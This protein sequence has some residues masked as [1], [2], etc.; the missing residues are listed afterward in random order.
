M[1]FLRGTLRDR[2]CILNAHTPAKKTKK[3]GKTMNA[4]FSSSHRAT[5]TFA[6]ISSAVLLLSY[7]FAA[8]LYSSTS[9]QAADVTS[10]S[11]A[12]A[13]SVEDVETNYTIGFTVPANSN[14]GAVI[15][16]FCDNDPIPNTTCTFTA[17][18][19]D[20][21][22]VDTNAGSIA[23]ES[24]GDAFAFTGA[25]VSECDNP[26][27]TAPAVGSQF[28][29]ITCTAVDDF[30]NAAST[31]SGTID[32]IDNPS[33]AT[34]SPANPNNTFYARIYVYNVTNPTNPTVGSGNTASS[35]NLEHT[36]GIA[37]S[38]AEQL[39]ITA[40]VQEILEFCVGTNATAPADC[41]AMTGNSVD[42]GVLDFASINRST[43]QSSP[44]QG[45]VM[46]RTNA[47][48]GINIDYFA[49][50]ATTGTNH[51][52][53]MRV[54]GAN[55]N[56][57]DVETD[58]CLLSAGTTQNT[59]T[60][61]TEEFGMCIFGI[62][63]SSGTTTNFA[64]GVAGDYDD[65]A[66][67]CDN[68]AGFAFDETGTADDLIDTSTVVNDEMAEIEFAATSAITTP[69]GIYE[70]TITFIGTSTF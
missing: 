25:T 6:W 7:V 43:Q 40:R 65:I 42:L 64:G 66:N 10:R 68:T 11:I 54:D 53:A 51:L 50:Q 70:T 52:G 38:T 37:M 41:S 20:I 35:T 36:G 31:F 23:T 69:T 63:T 3:K 58:Q 22:Q 13:S 45:S 59:I 4:L 34:D 62:D 48:G 56:A 5:R 1:V 49:E 9:V 21:P 61:G 14:V 32:D 12:M 57:G 39:T 17:V 15:I 26:A 60:A 8:T 19:D 16:E 28:V 44:S 30:S 18:G 46:A 27:L 47:S 55:C 67:T 29:E 2:Q 33:N 24:A